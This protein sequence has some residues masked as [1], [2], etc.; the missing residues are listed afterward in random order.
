MRFTS[1]AAPPARAP[2]TSGG[3]ALRI[4]SIRGPAASV[5]N[6]KT[7]ALKLGPDAKLRA[8]LLRRHDFY[9]A[10]TPQYLNAEMISRP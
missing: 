9:L 8:A 4:P 5:I 2:G 6:T 10:F 1:K 3:R 7:E